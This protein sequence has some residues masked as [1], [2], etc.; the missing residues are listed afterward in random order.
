MSSGSMPIEKVSAVER[1]VEDL[2]P[3]VV[4]QR[5]AAAFN[6]IAAE[7]RGVALG[8]EAD[9]VEGAEAAREALV[10]GQRG[11]DLGGREGDVQ[12]EA[13]AARRQP[14]ARS[15]WPIRRKW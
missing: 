6:Q 9:E 14:E 11:E 7:V 13:D 4:E 3:A 15:S 1:A 5:S 8:L 12:E 10:L 2:D